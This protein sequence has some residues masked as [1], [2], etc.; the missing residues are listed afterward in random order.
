MRALAKGSAQTESKGDLAALLSELH[1]DKF[2]AKMKEE[3]AETVSD[4][5]EL[6]AEELA[7]FCSG[8]GMNAVQR[9]K[10]SK[11]LVVSATAKNNV[12]LNEPGKWDFFLSHTQR[13]GEAKMLA[14]L[15]YYELTG[16]GLSVWLDVKMKV[17]DAASMEEGARNSKVCIPIITDNKKDSYFSR[18]MC[19]NELKWALRAGNKVVPVVRAEDKPRIGA[20]VAEGEKCGIELGNKNFVHIDRGSQRMLKASLEVMLEQAGML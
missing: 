13:D 1:L 5:V 18:E 2:A 19:R 17:C 7:E 16:R 14:E 20:F 15:L 9:N 6:S 3:G 8:A 4:L 12:I 10:L 11:A